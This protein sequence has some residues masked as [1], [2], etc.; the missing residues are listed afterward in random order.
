MD[1]SKIKNKALAKALDVIGCF[2]V[3][4]P[5][6]GITEIC[7]LLDLN[8]SNVHSI[9]STFEAYGYV[10]KNRSN[11]KYYLHSSILRL[12]GVLNRSR[13]QKEEIT[14]LVR[15]IADET[16]ETV[17]YGIRNGNSILYLEYVSS[18]S[19]V[20]PKQVIGVTAP[21]YCTSTGK[22]LLAEMD[23]R[24][25]DDIL[26]EGMPPLT[27]HTITTPE[28]MKLELDAIRVRGYSIDNMEHEYG[29]KG[30]GMT[31]H[32][33]EHNPVAAISVSGPSL[34]FDSDS[35]QKIAEIID[36]FRKKIAI[37]YF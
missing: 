23:E 33:M 24:D 14:K 22:A 19:L 34:R 20:V 15:M 12:A 36:R 13:P 21:L 5:E 4:R 29:V 16:G 32:D 17:Y 1:Q 2:S 9:I 31:V 35:I 37:T 7:T 10:K 26:S 6:L 8:K 11:N 3:D 18:T 25:V 27:D 28:K 30:V